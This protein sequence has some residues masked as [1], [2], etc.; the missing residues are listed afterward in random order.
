MGPHQST[1]QGSIPHV[2]AAPRPGYVEAP[3]SQPPKKN[4]RGLQ[5]FQIKTGL[6]PIGSISLAYI[7]VYINVMHSYII[8]LTTKKQLNVGKYKTIIN[9]SHWVSGIFFWFFYSDPYHHSVCCRGFEPFISKMTGIL[10]DATYLTSPVPVPFHC[11]GV[12]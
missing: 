2:F 12:N 1:S 3:L 7:Y 8:H 4:S 10:P 6:L 5:W 11:S 9:Q